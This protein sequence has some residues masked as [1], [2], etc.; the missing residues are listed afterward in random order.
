MGRLYIFP[1]SSRC[2]DTHILH[3]PH[4]S[5][6]VG[7]CRKQ[8][9]ETHLFA[10]YWL[11]LFLPGKDNNDCTLSIQKR[12]QKRDNKPARPATRLERERPVIFSL[13]GYVDVVCDECSPEAVLEMRY[14]IGRDITIIHDSSLFL[15]CKGP[16]RPEA[17]DRQ[18]FIT[19]F[20]V[21]LLQKK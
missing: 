6:R 11:S 5:V 21:K 13:V 20:N 2:L 19:L 10:S 14:K 9:R 18:Y 1:T 12:S 8:L 16:V 7:D 17:G 4:T 15:H 3:L